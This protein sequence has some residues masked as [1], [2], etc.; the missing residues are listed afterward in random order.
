MRTP[1]NPAA[2]LMA[3]ITAA[4][5][6]SLSGMPAAALPNPP[7]TLAR[8]AQSN[9]SYACRVVVMDDRTPEVTPIWTDNIRQ[10]SHEIKSML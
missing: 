10:C 3:G 9:G 7:A 8:D 4:A 5:A 6:L 2:R 1:T